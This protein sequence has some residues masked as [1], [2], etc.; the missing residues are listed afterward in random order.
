M[1]VLYF[2]KMGMRPGLSI[3]K[4]KEALLSLGDKLTEAEAIGICGSLARGDFDDKS[5]IDIFVIVK[6]GGSD[7]D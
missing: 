6:Q 2:A 3:E 7:I 1:E 4:V 5:D